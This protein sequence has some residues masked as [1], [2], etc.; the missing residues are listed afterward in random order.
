MYIT[1]Y[2]LNIFSIQNKMNIK[3]KNYCTFKLLAE[4][5]L[6]YRTTISLQAMFLMMIGFLKGNKI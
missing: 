3:M 5:N 4:V 1:Q 6:K 2:Q